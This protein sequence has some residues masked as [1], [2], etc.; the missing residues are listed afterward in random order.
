MP[1]RN[2]SVCRRKVEKMSW[3]KK[4]FAIKKEDNLI[5]S[6]EKEFLDKIAKKVVDKGMCLPAV[7]FLESVKPLNFIGSQI[8]LFFEPILKTF[9]EFKS[10]DRLI[11]ILEKRESI[12]VLINRLEYFEQ[13]KQEKKNEKKS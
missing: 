11:T 6:E 7:L 5:N 12:P 9:I 10:Y 3:L 1:K 13:L 4:A 2:N 8:L